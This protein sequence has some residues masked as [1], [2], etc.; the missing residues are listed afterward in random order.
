MSDIMGKYLRKNRNLVEDAD[1]F[2][3]MDDQNILRAG[4]VAELETVNL[5]MGFAAKTKNPKIRKVILDIAYEEKVHIQEFE[6]LL[7]EIDSDYT[8]AADQAEKEHKEL[9]A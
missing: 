3:T 2:E 4:M 9:T 1:R 5:Y 8:N 6:D 7:F